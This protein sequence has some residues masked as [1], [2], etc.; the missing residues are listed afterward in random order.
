MKSK[1][2][3]T[4][5]FY[6]NGCRIY[7]IRPKSCRLFPFRVEEETTPQGDI[8]LNISYNKSC[9]GMG[10]GKMAD[11]KSLEKL[12]CDQFEERSDSVANEVRILAEEGKISR[13]ARG[14][15]Q[16]SRPKIP[17]QI[18]RIKEQSLRHWLSKV[19][20]LK[21]CIGNAHGLSQRHD[22]GGEIHDS[23]K[24][25]C[26]VAARKDYRRGGGSQAKRSNDQVMHI[27]WRNILMAGAA[28]VVVVIAATSM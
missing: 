11:K 7:S 9:P 22:L 18:D 3:T 17:A 24:E 8:I 26:Y 10:K 19:F 12:V 13:D 20:L 27:E 23:C 2:D 28:V 16:P 14:L 15:P 6:D 4:C 1:V 25:R 21:G 5:V